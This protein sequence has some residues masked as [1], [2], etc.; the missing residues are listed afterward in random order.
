M[1]LWKAT[2][3]KAWNGLSNLACHV[4]PRTDSSA[5]LSPHA[6]VQQNS[7][8]KG[9]TLFIKTQPRVL[10]HKIRQDKEDWKID[11]MPK[12]KMFN[13]YVHDVAHNIPLACCTLCPINT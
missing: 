1:L 11:T 7:V 13:D 8:G 2:L 3:G 9:V 5:S 12:F 4:L 6:A 10:L